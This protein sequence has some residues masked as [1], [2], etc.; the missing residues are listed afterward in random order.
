MNWGTPTT[1]DWK[2]GTAE[3]VKNVPVNGL[4]GR[5][6]HATYGQADQVKTS[7]DGSRLV[8]NPAWVMCLMG[9][10]LEKIFFAWREMES[11]NKQ[12]N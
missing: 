10:R 9:T 8:L 1:R 7:T 4:L 2:D 5:M 3:S 12:Q 6:V 11:L